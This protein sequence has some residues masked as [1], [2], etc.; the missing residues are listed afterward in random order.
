M[1]LGEARSETGEYGLA[2]ST[3]SFGAPSSRS[4]VERYF[5]RYCDIAEATQNPNAF[6]TIM[7]KLENQFPLDEWVRKD[8]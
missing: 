2:E 8:K 4:D 6:P 7:T 1:R 3:A 5:R